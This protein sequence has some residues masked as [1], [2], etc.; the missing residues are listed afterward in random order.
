MSNIVGSFLLVQDCFAQKVH[1]LAHWNYELQEFMLIGAR[2]RP[3]ETF[4]H[5]LICEIE[6]T[7]SLV[8]FNDFV[9]SQDAFAHLAF[10]EQ[11]S[12]LQAPEHCVIELFEFQLLE[13]SGRKILE[14][15]LRNRWIT[16]QEIEAGYCEDGFPVS[17]LFRSLFQKANLANRLA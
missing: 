12:S 3:F 6:Q 2:K 13:N 14:N 9:L 4:Q 15:D 8:P 1:W 17:G 10:S 7:F 16:E 11:H 5:R